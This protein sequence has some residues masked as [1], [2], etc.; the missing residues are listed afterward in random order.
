MPDTDS[1]RLGTPEKFTFNGPGVALSC[2]VQWG[3]AA[4]RY[5]AEGG[6]WVGFSP[7]SPEAA[8]LNCFRG[9]LLGGNGCFHDYLL[10]EGGF[11]R[12]GM[13]KP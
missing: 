10:D 13:I 1:K 12:V 6:G 11:Y 4:E 5:F 3:A 7:R 9:W 2:T 8:V